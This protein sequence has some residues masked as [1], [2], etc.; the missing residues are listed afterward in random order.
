MSNVNRQLR[1]FATIPP[2][3]GASDYRAVVR[4]AAKAAESAGMFGALVYSDNHTVDPWLVAQEVITAT[5]A[6]E[7]LIALQPIYSHPSTIAKIVASYAH[8]YGR[9]ICLNLVAGGVR[10]DLTALNDETEHD[11]R[12]ARLTEYTSLIL[13]LLTDTEPVTFGGEFYRVRDLTLHPRMP[14][15]LLPGLYMS[16]SSTAGRKAGE[17]IGAISVRY[18]SPREAVAEIDESAPRSGGVRI[19]IIARDTDDEAWTVAH[20]RFPRTR[21]GRIQQMLIRGLSDSHW[22]EQLSTED[23][24]PGG[25]ESPYWMGPF[26]TSA[27][28]CPYLVG[29][30]DKVEAEIARYVSAGCRD[31]VLDTA[32]EESDYAAYTESFDRVLARQPLA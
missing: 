26:L 6:F 24:F 14:Q 17:E 19:G 29:S 3:V 32:H 25:P 8:V 10:G 4:D 23:E 30:H 28:Y 22:F 21:A 12:Y 27:T 15:D 9:R 31:F 1:L 13:R 2:A 11:R 5:E 18:P 16:G 20:R 7:P